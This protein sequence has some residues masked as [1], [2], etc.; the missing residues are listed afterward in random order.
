VV[1]SLVMIIVGALTLSLSAQA[2]LGGVAPVVPSGVDPAAAA[3]AVCAW[4]VVGSSSN[5]DR[6]DP[7][8]LFTNSAWPTAC[9]ATNDMLNRTVKSATLAD[10]IYVKV[11]Y[12]GG[13]K[14]G[15]RSVAASLYVPEYSGSKPCTVT[16]KRTSDGATSVASVVRR[17]GFWSAETL[18]LYDNSVESYASVAC[19]YGG[20]TYTGR[21][22]SW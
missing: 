6:L 13:T 11:T 19:T 8:E 18:A 20:H 1:V 21:T 16:L 15:C 7:N 22:G 9:T 12:S 10:G 3:P 14:A 17:G 2:A 4:T 5:C